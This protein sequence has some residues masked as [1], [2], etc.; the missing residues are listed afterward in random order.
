[1]LKKKRLKKF[2]ETGPSKMSNR[3]TKEYR[4]SATGLQIQGEGNNQEIPQLTKKLTKVWYFGEGN[5]KS[6]AMTHKLAHK[7]ELWRREK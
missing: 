2:N 5:N 1:M 7:D 4:S 3:T 6:N